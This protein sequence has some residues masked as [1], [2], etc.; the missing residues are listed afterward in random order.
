MLTDIRLHELTS[1]RR[2]AKNTIWNFLGQGLPLLVGLVAIPLL[3]DGLGTERFGIL[4][5]AWMV[6]GYFSL[7]DVGLGRA[8]TKF[9]AERLGEGRAAE[10]AVLIWTALV[11][12]AVLGIIGALLLA[13]LTPWLT[14]RV[15]AIPI[16]LQSEAV[17]AFY[18]LAASVPLVITTVGLAGIL[19]AYQRFDLVA[20][21][22]IPMGIWTFLGPLLAVGISNDLVTVVLVL[23]F[24]RLVAAIAHIVL[25][26]RTVSKLGRKWFPG[27]IA[28]GKSLLAYGGWMTV[29][30]VV[31]PLMVRLDR[32]VIGIMLTMSAVAYYATPYEIVT[33]LWIIPN[34]IVGVLFPAFSSALTGDRDRAARLFERGVSYILLLM[35]P[36]ALIVTAFA[37]EGLTLWLGEDFAEQSTPALRW[38]AI[39]VLINSLAH[40]PFGFLQADGRPDLTAKLHLVELPVY[41]VLLWWLLGLRGIEGAAIAWAVRVTVD[42]AALYFLAVPRIPRVVAA[43]GPML[44]TLAAGLGAI[45]LCI[46]IPSVGARAI[47]VLCGLV[48]YGV[49]VWYVLLRGEERAWIGR[50]LGAEG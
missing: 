2:L 46:V 38:L 28:I 6:I 12:M 20:A 25:C 41:F 47:V 22:R 39:G 10:V 48:A 34:A 33:R 11:M 26:A 31:G 23:V 3:V 5:L 18:L 36:F 32:F 8:L 50:R 13:I 21:V 27:S 7:F 17:G 1:G 35:L 42:A 37:P 19:Q 24:G 40:V 14:T 15:L 44:G 29:T 49:V 43:L 30:N 9:V 16:E 4:A 45:A